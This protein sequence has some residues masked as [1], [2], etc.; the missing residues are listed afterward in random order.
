MTIE[1]I[2]G[3]SA[4]ELQKVI[5][6]GELQKIADA[7][8]WLKITRPE[9]ADKPEKKS[10]VRQIGSSLSDEKRAKA[11]RAKQIAEQFGFDLE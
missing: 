6:T 3:C 4:T 10:H 1:E 5:D 9:L 7:N 8:G 11:L 2:C